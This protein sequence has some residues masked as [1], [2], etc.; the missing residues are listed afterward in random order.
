MHWKMLALKLAVAARP[1]GGGPQ[2]PCFEFCCAH[3]TTMRHLLSVH[4]YDVPDY[5]LVNTRRQYGGDI[6][7]AL[8][9]RSGRDRRLP[10][11]IRMHT[12]INKPSTLVSTYT[13]H[14]FTSSAQ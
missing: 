11:I 7:T 2:I 8:P 3:C 13:P 10:A 9:F 6:A 4:E 1:N 14:H 12:E 5:W